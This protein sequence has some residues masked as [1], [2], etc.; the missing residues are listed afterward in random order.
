MGSIHIAAIEDDPEAVLAAVRELGAERVILVEYGD[1]GSAPDLEGVLEPLGVET[2][3]RA[4]DG[5]MLL[6]TVQLV[7]DVARTYRNRREDLVVNLGAAGRYQSCALLSAAFVA[8]VR[9]IDWHE[10]EVRTFPVL[11]FSYDE[12]VGGDQLEILQGLAELDDEDRHLHALVSKTS[13]D[14]STVSYLIR[15]GEQAR[16]LEELDLVEVDAAGEG[17]VRLTLTP[18]GET[19]AHGMRL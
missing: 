16:G 12:V 11:D 10:G 7:Q 17:P 18:M 15:G 3:R 5:S 1:E 4:V 19:L 9:A 6:G 8:G 2:E 14:A 13:L